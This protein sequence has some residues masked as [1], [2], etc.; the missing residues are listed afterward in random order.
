ML[1]HFYLS[2]MFQPSYLIFFALNIKFPFRFIYVQCTYDW[3][4]TIR[5]LQLKHYNHYD[6]INIAVT[7]LHTILSSQK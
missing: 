5:T 2:K 6:R 3:A 4:V 1:G 7:V